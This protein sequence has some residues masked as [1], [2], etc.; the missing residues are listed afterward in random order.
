M[1]QTY[2]NRLLH[3]FVYANPI[4]LQTSNLQQGNDDI[5]DN[6]DLCNSRLCKYREGKGQ[7]TATLPW[8]LNKPL[9]CWWSGAGNIHNLCGNKRGIQHWLHLVVS[10]PMYASTSVGKQM[11]II[12]HLRFCKFDRTVSGYCD[13]YIWFPIS[14]HMCWGPHVAPLLLCPKHTSDPSGNSLLPPCLEIHNF[15]L[16][17]VHQE[18]C[19]LLSGGTGASFR[20]DQPITSEIIGSTVGQWMQQNENRCS[21]T[22]YNRY[23]RYVYMYICVCGYVC[24]CVCLHMPI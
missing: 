9:W 2:L 10:S 16:S 8:F 11:P 15:T 23:I 7:D 20:H 5:D 19:F 1:Q 14:Y 22:W 12:V 3:C 6:R 4:V 17:D 18:T 24:M 21:G 13:S